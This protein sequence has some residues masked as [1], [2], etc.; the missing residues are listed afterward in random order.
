MI[1]RFVK[2]LSF[3]LVLLPPASR[4][5]DLNQDLREAAKKGDARAVESLLGRGADANAR[6]PYGATA[7]LYASDKGHVEVVK[8]LLKHKADVNLKDTFYGGTPLGFALSN[9]HYDVAQLLV[10]NGAKDSSAL[11]IAAGAGQTELVKAVLTK[12]KPSA[13]Q[14]SKA[15]A[16]VPSNHAE[17]AELLKKA[18]AKP[19]P[20]TPAVQ[21]MSPAGLQ[22]YLG[23]FGNDKGVEYVLSANIDKLTLAWLGQPLYTLSPAA[24]GSFKDAT[25]DVTVT[26]GETG[27]K[28][29]SMTLKAGSS[30]SQFQRMTGPR[31]PETII[32]A[33]PGKITPQNWPSFRGLYASGVADGQY[34]PTQWDV[35]KGQNIAWKTPIPGIGHS[36]P[37]IWGERI[38][39]TTAVSGDPKAG[40]RP[41]LYGDVTSVDDKTVHSWHVLCL[42]RHDG[43]ILWDRVS[44]MRVP[45]VKR[46]LKGSH[47]N[48]TAATDGQHVVACFGS[49]GLYCYDLDGKLLWKRDLGVLDS[50]FFFDA[51]YQ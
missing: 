45:A 40:V 22:R 15:L 49:E 48:C 12:S 11:L 41:G 37:I 29:T 16:A 26:F 33:A 20:V 25:E 6:T 19:A 21:A 31:K 38:F 32:E 18:G 42:D 34:P 35:E 9:K 1:V 30:E 51:D 13:A 8:I 7:I 14:L 46:H 27:G 10:E 17:I 23:T 36:C 5:A 2:L 3:L 28:V 44:C 47:A 24:K 39:L 4:A 43:K 50:G